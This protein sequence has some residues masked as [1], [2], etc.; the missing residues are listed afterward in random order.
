M[1]TINK[2]IKN[3]NDYLSMPKWTRT[4]NPQLRRLML[5]PIELW[6]HLDKFN[7]ISKG[8]N[9]TVGAT[10][11]EPAT[12]WSQTKRS[13]RAELR[14]ENITQ[15]LEFKNIAFIADCQFSG[16]FFVKMS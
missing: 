1:L 15:K 5:Y 16:K 10:G 6:A 12:S 7:A 14:P 2:N 8:I 11:F 4:T 13:S 9:S 3:D